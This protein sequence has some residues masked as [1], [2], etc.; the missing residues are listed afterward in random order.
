MHSDEHMATAP[1]QIKPGKLYWVL[2]PATGLEVMVR[3]VT[4]SVGLD[5]AAW[6]CRKG[7][8]TFLHVF[9][10]KDFVRPVSDGK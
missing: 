1:A 5:E 10:E 9:D 3:P 8:D 7:S 4:R 6:T 2:C